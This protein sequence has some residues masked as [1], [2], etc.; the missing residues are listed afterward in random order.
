MS[1]GP[2]LRLWTFKQAGMQAGEQT[3]GLILGSRRLRKRGCMSRGLLFNLLEDD[4]GSMITGL[5]KAGLYI[6]F[7]KR[8]LGEVSETCIADC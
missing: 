7:S 5:V 8:V 6:T 2:Y 4:A 3:N 1:R